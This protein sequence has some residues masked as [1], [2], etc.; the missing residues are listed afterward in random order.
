MAAGGTSLVMSSRTLGFR[1][2]SMKT[3]PTIQQS[4]PWRTSRTRSTN[5]AFAPPSWLLSAQAHVC[6]RMRTSKSSQAS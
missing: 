6:V 1:D 4:S 2:S 5:W 3:V